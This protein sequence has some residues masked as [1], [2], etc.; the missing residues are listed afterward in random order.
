LN[1]DTGEFYKTVKG[2]RTFVPTTYSKTEFNATIEA[3]LIAE[4]VQA[5]NPRL[6]FSVGGNLLGINHQKLIVPML[7]ELQKLRARVEELESQ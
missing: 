5:I 3:G 2:E 4:D 6:V 1:A 7:V